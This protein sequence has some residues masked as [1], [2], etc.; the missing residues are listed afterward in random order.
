MNKLE[1]PT[2]SHGIK[3]KKTRTKQIKPKHLHTFLFKHL[4]FTH[5]SLML[6]FTLANGILRI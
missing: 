3:A 6:T 2:C 4:D 5:Q 1:I